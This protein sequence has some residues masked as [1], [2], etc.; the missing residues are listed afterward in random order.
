MTRRIT[1]ALATAGAL[2]MALG[3]GLPAWGQGTTE[4]VSLGTGNVR[5]DDSSFG[6]ALSADGRYVAFGSAASN[7]VPN[8]TNSRSDVFVRDRRRGTT[9]RVSFGPRGVQGNH[10]SGTNTLALSAD[11]RY[12]AFTSEARNL[13]PG[14]TNGAEDVFVRDRRTGRTTRVSLGTG[15]V[16]GNGSS[17]SPALSADGRVVAFVSQA[18]NLVPGGNGGGQDVFVHD[19]RT[20][21]TARASLGSNGVQGNDASWSPTLSADGRVVAFQSDA[22]NL[23]PGDTNSWP[24]VFVH[25]RRTRTIERA[26]VGPDGIQGNYG[27][28]SPALSADGRLVAFYSDASNLVPGGTNGYRNVFVRRLGR[29]R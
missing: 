5:G 11:G 6:A 23:V 4:W 7:L 22:S 17:W 19:R 10:D 13:V 16:Q 20:G 29:G 28:S 14:D 9:E 27:S 2:A 3:A 15:G 21:I 26:S 24:D 1:R 12:V 18:S 8:D 25:D